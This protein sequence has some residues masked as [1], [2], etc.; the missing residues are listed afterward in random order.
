M[1][2]KLIKF[3]TLSKEELVNEIKPHIPTDGYLYFSYPTEDVGIFINN[4]HQ[5][6]L[7]IDVHKDD[8]WFA[9][10]IGYKINGNRLELIWDEDTQARIDVE[11]KAYYQDKAEFIARW[12]CE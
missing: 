4:G 7:F 9:D 1:V 3:K 10:A 8:Y 11:K 12:G 2:M 5:L 6:E